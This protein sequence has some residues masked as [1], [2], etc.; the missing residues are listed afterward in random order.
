MRVGESNS[1]WNSDGL[2]CFIS[3]ECAGTQD[4]AIRDKKCDLLCSLEQGAV[5]RSD[6]GGWH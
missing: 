3:P 4:H 5:E 6:N 2:L 1:E